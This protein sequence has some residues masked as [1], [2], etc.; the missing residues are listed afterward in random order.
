MKKGSLYAAML[1]AIGVVYGDIGTSPLYALKSSFIIASLEVNETNIFGLISTFI[2]TLIMVVSVKYVSIVLKASYKGEGGILALSSLIRKFSDKGHFYVVM[3]GLLGFAL[4]FGDCIITP[5]IS[6]L[7]AVEGLS[8]ASKE[9]SVYVMPISLIILVCL[10]AVQSKGSDVI[11]RFFGPVMLVWFLTIGGLGIYQI[12]QMPEILHALNPKYAFEF[13]LHNGIKSFMVLG[14]AILVVTGGEALYAD[15]GHFG[16][17]AIKLT[18]HF[19]VFPS[20]SLNYLG[21]GAVLIQYPEA[22]EHPFFSMA[23]DYMIYPMVILATVA[24]IIA[25]QAVISGVFSMYSHAMMLNYLPRMKMNFTSSHQKGQVYIPTI[26]VILGILTIF[27]VII[28]RTSDAMSVA[29]GFSVSGLMLIT[30]ILSLILFIQRRGLIISGILSIILLL[31]L[32]FF[33]SNAIKIFEGAWY[34]LFVASIVFYM[35]RV[36]IKGGEVLIKQQFPKSESIQSFVKEYELKHHTKIPATAIFMTRHPKKVPHSLLIHLEHNKFLHSKMLFISI[37]TSNAPRVH[38]KKRY[39]VVKIS[40]DIYAIAVKYGYQEIPNMK[41]MM[42]W[43]VEH[44]ILSDYES[45]TF[46]MSKG[47]PVPAQGVGL[48][49]ISEHIYILMYKFAAPAYEF[50]NIPNDKVLELGVRYRI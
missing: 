19:F 14:A 24:T 37:I 49:K 48:G 18:W 41:K 12:I 20:L 42:K 31:D 33:S 26:N 5:A 28:F 46:F 7:S 8:I 45:V 50:Y 21:Q 2:W 36:W 3:L 47:V 17:R 35:A 4:F 13:F 34:S 11:G 15:L 32:I 23:P 9:F 44:N 38:F 43:A 6:V 27:S 10:F 40:K 39:T 25:S 1:G 22:I 29:Y 30:T 16:G